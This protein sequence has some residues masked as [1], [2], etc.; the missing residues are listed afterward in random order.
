[1]DFTALSAARTRR[2]FRRLGDP[3]VLTP[4]GGAAVDTYGIVETR[5]PVVGDL[6]QLLDERPSIEL[7][8][9]DVGQPRRATV[10]TLGKTYDIDQPVPATLRSQYDSGAGDDIIVRYYLRERRDG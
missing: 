5:T 4:E 8:R 1:M 10:V 6:G 3:C 9:E 7:L 2:I